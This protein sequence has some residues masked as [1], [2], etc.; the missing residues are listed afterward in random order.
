MIPD[1][2]S[3]KETGPCRAAFRHWYFDIVTGKCRRFIYG[4][5]Q[6][7][8]NNY[9]SKKECEAFCGKPS[10]FIKSEFV[11]NFELINYLNYYIWHSMKA[12]IFGI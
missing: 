10:M 4:G 5:C 6:G 9:R 2:I 7:N 8:G 3:P 11:F 12:I 1:C